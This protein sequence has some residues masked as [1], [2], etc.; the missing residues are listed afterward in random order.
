MTIQEIKRDFNEIKRKV[1][2]RFHVHSE[3]SQKYLG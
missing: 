2:E 3:K 1:V